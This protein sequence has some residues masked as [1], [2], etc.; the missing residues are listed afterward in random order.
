[1]KDTVG[2]FSQC[3]P[4]FLYISAFWGRPNAELISGFRRCIRDELGRLVKHVAHR[5]DSTK[6]PLVTNRSF[7]NHDQ[8]QLKIVEK[9]LE[10]ASTGQVFARLLI[11]QFTAT[12]KN[13]KKEKERT[14]GTLS[15]RV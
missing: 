1:M 12:Q 4:S 11:I 14:A 7:G 15:T 3:K 8:T 10:G 5:C 13:L 2:E 6:M 9:T